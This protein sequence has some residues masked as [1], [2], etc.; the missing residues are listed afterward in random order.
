MGGGFWELFFYVLHLLIYLTCIVL[1]FVRS[2]TTT[3]RLF[4]ILV[5]IG[6]FYISFEIDN[7]YIGSMLAI[8]FIGAMG[9]TKLFPLHA[10]YSGE[11]AI[12]SLLMVLIIPKN[13]PLL[14]I[15]MHSLWILLIAF[16]IAGVLFPAP[17]E[18]NPQT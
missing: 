18:K 1:V 6:F 2:K 9:A 17:E 12:I 5:I 15:V 10:V 11:I 14:Y 16:W 13:N 4:Y 3:A 8:A 7:F